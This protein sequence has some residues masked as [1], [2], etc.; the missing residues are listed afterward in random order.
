MPEVILVAGRGPMASRAIRSCQEAGA[1]AI[2]VYSEADAN[3]LHVRLADE[4][5][6]IGDSAPESSYLDDASLVEAAQVS[7]A[8]AVLP[9]HPILA[10]SPELARA[11]EDAGLLWIGPDSHAL[12]AVRELEW[13][14]EP[15]TGTSSGWVIGVAD[16]F[17]IDG[18]VVRRMNADGATLWWTSADEP[19]ELVLDGLP[20]AAK[21][22][23]SLSDLVVG[24]GW[25]GLVSVTFA[26]DGSPLAIRGGVPRELGIAE[27]RTGR[28]LVKGALALA[29]DGSPPSGSPGAP[30]AVGGVIRATAVPGPGQRVRITEFTGPTGPD[31]IWEPGYA[32]G[33]SIW[34]WYDPVLAVLA[35]PGADVSA[36]V[37]GFLGATA[38][39]SIVAVPNDLEQLRERAEDLA[40]RLRDRAQ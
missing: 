11:I 29:D 6:L 8:H 36:A 30:A 25:R 40:A 35:V 12:A 13:A 2:A 20:P 34:P 32:A 4:A 19:A 24:L 22:L 28:D 23:A 16:G 10:G 9:V 17:R 7:S 26:E 27:L 14:N 38:G 1:K 39:V 21:L 5:V 37:T 15:V 3:A 18:V 31:L 33:D